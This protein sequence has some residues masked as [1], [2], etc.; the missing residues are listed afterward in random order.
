MKKRCRTLRPEQIYA[1]VDIEATGGS[2]GA[3]ERVIQFACVLLKNDEVIHTFETFVNPGRNIPRN[4]RNLTGI[5]NKDVKTAP[6]FE[7]VAPIIIRLLKDSVF[8]AHNVGFDFRVLNE[9]LRRDDFDALDSR[10]IETV[11]VPHILFPTLRSVHLEDV[12]SGM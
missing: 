8:V 2:I 12:A 5:S 6:Y 10:A 1:I 9:Q 3:D 7:E 4:I 11:G